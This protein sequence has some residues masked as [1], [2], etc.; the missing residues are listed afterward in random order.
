MFSS[1]CSR[2]TAEGICLFL[3][4]RSSLRAPALTSVTSSQLHVPTETGECVPRGGAVVGQR[5]LVTSAGTLRTFFF[6]F[7]CERTKVL[8]SHR[9]PQT[10]T[11]LH[12]PPQCHPESIRFVLP[13]CVG[14]CVLLSSPWRWWAGLLPP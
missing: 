8:Q 2:D 10:S 11:H 13:V 7:F 4:M 14:V 12:R 3:L 6:F 9:P 5:S 1:F